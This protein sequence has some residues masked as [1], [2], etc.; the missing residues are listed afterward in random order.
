MK[1]ADKAL[2]AAL[3]VLVLLRATGGGLVAP[4]IAGPA[5][6][7]IVHETA[8]DT[9]AQRDMLAEIQIGK[10]PVAEYLKSKGHTIQV[11]DDDTQDENG[12]RVVDEAWLEGVRLPAVVILDATSRQAQQRGQLPATP[13][14]LLGWLKGKGL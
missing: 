9:V 1:P 7:V 8:D 6:V 4:A 11:L 12:Q 13:D 2:W 5:R 14:G 3:V 10:G